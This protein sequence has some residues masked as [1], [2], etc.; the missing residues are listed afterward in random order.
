MMFAKGKNMWNSRKSLNL[1]W[2]CT[3][4]FIVG[5][6]VFAVFLPA[7]LKVYVAV[8]PAYSSVIQLTPLMIVLYL[9]CIPSLLALIALDRL[10][11]NLRRNEIFTR[12]NVSLLRAISWCCFAVAI[13]IMAAISYYFFFIFHLMVVAI[14]ASFIGLIVRVVKNVIEQA[15]LLKEEQ[16]LTV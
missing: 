5:I 3:K 2:I 15:V 14:I 7:L 8:S 12:R 13:L 11:S 9:C 16:D 1:S 6:F 4:C 10:L